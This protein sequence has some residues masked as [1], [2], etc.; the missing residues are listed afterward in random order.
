[1]AVLYVVTLLSSSGCPLA[2]RAGAL[3]SC[4]V[5]YAT[6]DASGTATTA[7]VK[8][9]DCPVWDHQQECR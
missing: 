8:D 6:A 3:P 7:L 1:M 4:C 9:T 5:S 2:E